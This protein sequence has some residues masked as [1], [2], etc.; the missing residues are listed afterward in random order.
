MP[1]GPDDFVADDLSDG[2]ITIDEQAESL[3]ELENEL[4]SVPG[5]TVATDDRYDAGSVVGANRVPLAACPETYPIEFD[6]AQLLR[7]D[8]ELPSTDRTSVYLEWPEKITRETPLYQLLEAVDVEVTSFADILGENIPL[9]VADTHYVADV[10]YDTE[11][12]SHH[13][14]Q[15]SYTTTTVSVDESEDTSSRWYYVVLGSWLGW[16]FLW[17]VVSS[18]LDL[19]IPDAPLGMIVLLSWVLFPIGLYN[20]CKHVTANSDWSPNEWLY[21][22]L[23]FIWA[24]NLPLGLIYLY[25]RHNATFDRGADTTRFTDFLERLV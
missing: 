11:T 25:K 3:L 20:D 18:P 10:T 17:I 15:Q 8:V 1:D 12:A 7:L 14:Q 21:S 22:I 5:A 4:S 2:G 19:L 9:R 23:S 13:S 16:L 24:V 6:S